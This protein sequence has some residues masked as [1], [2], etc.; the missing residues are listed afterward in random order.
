M[1]D[2]DEGLK[3]GSA[4]QLRETKM[5]EAVCGEVGESGGKGCDFGLTPAVRGSRGEGWEEERVLS[6]SLLCGRVRKMEGKGIPCRLCAA[7]GSETEGRQ[8]MR[9]VFGLSAVRGSEKERSAG[10][11]F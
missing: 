6:G 7:R 11:C 9:S 3:G 8:G 5:K 10:E 4:A 1:T 2:R